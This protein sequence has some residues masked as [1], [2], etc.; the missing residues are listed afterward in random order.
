MRLAAIFAESL[1]SLRLF[2]LFPLQ[3]LFCFFLELT[4]ARDRHVLAASIDEILDHPNT[5]SDAFGTNALPCHCLG[6]RSSVFGE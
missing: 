2:R 4:F 5:G 1:N 6:D 3:Q